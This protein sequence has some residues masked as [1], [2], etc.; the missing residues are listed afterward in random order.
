MNPLYR[1]GLATAKHP[2]RTICAW[3]VVLV[4]VG[5]AATA[6]GGDTQ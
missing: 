5:A 6:W 2:W 1:L 4:A 3:V